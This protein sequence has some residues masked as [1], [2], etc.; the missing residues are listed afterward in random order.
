MGWLSRFFPKQQKQTETLTDKDLTVEQ[1]KSA[2]NWA[3][4]F[5]TAAD[6]NFGTD[7]VTKP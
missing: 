2:S 3:Q 7:K 5:Q 4:V 1:L 6:L